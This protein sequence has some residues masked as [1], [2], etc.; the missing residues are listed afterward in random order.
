MTVYQIV[1]SEFSIEVDFETME[2]QGIIWAIFVYANNKE[3]VRAEQWQELW[4]KS[5]QWGSKW[6]LGGEFNDIRKPQKKI[7]GRTRSEA[8]YKGFIEFIERMNMEEI[9]F[10]GQ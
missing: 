4:T 8:S 5:G 6:I 1:S 2:T 3:K 9:E 7:G 10:Q